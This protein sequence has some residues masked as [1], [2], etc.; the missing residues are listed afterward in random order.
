VVSVVGN[1]SVCIAGIGGS[2]VAHRISTD[3]LL[4]W[5]FQRRWGWSDV[6]HTGAN[7]TL[8][9][10]GRGLSLPSLL[11]RCLLLSSSVSDRVLGQGNQ[12]L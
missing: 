12:I 4:W 7:K 9:R 5:G 3:S 1:P 11:W 10:L 8:R 2:G 6:Y